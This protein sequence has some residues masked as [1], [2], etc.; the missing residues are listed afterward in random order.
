MAICI[1]ELEEGDMRKVLPSLVNTLFSMLQ[2][3]WLVFYC[4]VWAIVFT[5]C[6]Q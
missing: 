4:V 5:S 1:P 6:Y 3:F 2:R